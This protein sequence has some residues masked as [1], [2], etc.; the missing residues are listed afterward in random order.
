MCGKVSF[1]SEEFYYC[2]QKMPISYQ[3]VIHIQANA[4]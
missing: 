4:F 3:H 2:F 1:L